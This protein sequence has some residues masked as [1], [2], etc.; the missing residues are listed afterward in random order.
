MFFGRLRHAARTL[1]FRLMVWNATVVLVTALVTLVGLREGVRWTIL[2]ELDQQLTGDLAEVEMNLADLGPRETGIDRM[3]VEQTRTA[4]LRQFLEELNRRARGHS[5]HGWFVQLLDA[6]GQPVWASDNTPAEL[7]GPIAI[8]NGRPAGWRDFRIVQ[9][10]ATSAAQ[11]PLTVRVGVSTAF[12]ARDVAVIDWFVTLAVGVVLFI[13]PLIGYWLAGRATRPLSH[14]I[15]TTARLKPTQLSDRLPIRNTEDELDRLSETINGLLD[16]IAAYLQHRRDFLANAAHELRTPLAAIRSS[17]EVALDG[18]RSR[19]DYDELLSEVVDECVSLEVLVNQLLLIA[20]SEKDCPAFDGRQVSLTD[21]VEQ[22]VDMFRG[23]TESREIE[24]SL[25]AAE[26]MIV[27]GNRH[28]LRQVL[29]NL[30][31]NAVT[32]TPGGGRVCVAL[33]ADRRRKQCVLR[34]TDTGTGIP[35]AD[36]PHVFERFYRGDKSRSH[37][38]EHHGT[39]LGLS[40]CQAV[41]R[42]HG[43]QIFVESQPGRGTTMT[44]LLPLAES[45]RQ[46]QTRERHPITSAEHPVRG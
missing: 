22:A 10:D 13:A 26:R 9:R 28:H 4:A 38:K 6:A 12:L 2:R 23:V 5:R 42:A 35:S 17:V 44:A 40:I 33:T 31:D 20:E 46:P 32:Y 36:L 25:E 15:R 37:R 30:L 7:S 16:R 8:R 29:N 3:A 1:R 41:V 19:E 43:G 18:D 27:V 45:D 11:S 14:I 21:I 34:V 24:L 39:G